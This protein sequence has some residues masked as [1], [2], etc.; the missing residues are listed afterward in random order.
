LTGDAYEAWVAGADPETGMRKGR[1]RPDDQAVRFVEVT[2]NGPKSWSLAAELHPDLAAAYDAAQDSAA[3][4]IIHWLG[5]HATTRVG[6]RGGQ[7]QVPV[8]QLE[9]V[10]GA[11]LHLPG[12]R[13]APSSA[14]ADQ[15]QG[16][17]RRALARPHTVGCGTP[18]TR[19]TALGLPPSPP[20]RSSGPLAAHGFTLDR[21]GEVEQLAEFVGPSVPEP[22]RSAATSTATKPIGLPRTRVGN[23]DRR[24]DH[25]Y[26]LG[27]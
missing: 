12:G 18:S 17:R 23:P 2:V 4:Q 22:R 21:E 24:C 5:D 25:V 8:E 1:L 13:S 6:P 14:P 26:G 16:V 11:A 27:R 3:T 9:S 15:L 10:T 19:S 20:T 7:V